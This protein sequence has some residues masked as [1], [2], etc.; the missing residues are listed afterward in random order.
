MTGNRYERMSDDE[1]SEL[2][3]QRVKKTG[4][5]KKTALEAQLELWKRHHWVSDDKWY[6]DGVID[7]FMEDI[8]YDGWGAE[9]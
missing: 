1:L 4:C 8:E 9:R 2:A 5:F 3:K 6:D 7:L